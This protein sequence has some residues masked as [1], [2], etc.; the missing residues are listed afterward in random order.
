MSPS[1]FPANSPVLS[2]QQ[3]QQQQQRR[4]GTPSYPANA[5]TS[6]A[7]HLSNSPL[8]SNTSASGQTAPP[9]NSSRIPLSRGGLPARNIQDTTATVG[10]PPSPAAAALSSPSSNDLSNYAGDDEGT[11]SA[12]LA[13]DRLSSP[14]S[15]IGLPN[16]RLAHLQ[17][18]ALPPPVAHPADVSS[19]SI[20]TPLAG[21]S[22]LP[23][24]RVT[25]LD[26]R[27]SSLTSSM[28]SG[29]AS[30]SSSSS[31]GAFNG[32]TDGR[33]SGVRRQSSEYLAGSEAESRDVTAR[34]NPRKPG[35][36]AGDTKEGSAHGILSAAQEGSDEVSDGATASPYDGDVEFAA[37]TPISQQVTHLSSAQVVANAASSPPM[38]APATLADKAGGDIQTAKVRDRENPVSDVPCRN[39]LATGKARS[40][41]RSSMELSQE[42]IRAQ[43]TALNS[44]EVAAA[45]IVRSKEGDTSS[46][47]GPNQP[48][49]PSRVVRI[50][51]QASFEDLAGFTA[52]TAQWRVAKLSGGSNSTDALSN[53]VTNTGKPALDAPG[54][55]VHVIVGVT[56]AVSAAQ[57]ATS[58]S[59]ADRAMLARNCRWVDEVVEDVPPLDRVPD[60]DDGSATNQ[61]L[62]EIGADFL[63]Q[64]VPMTNVASQGQNRRT[65]RLPDPSSMPA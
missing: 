27:S 11:I 9:S 48:R 13:G 20:P 37:R 52:S 33:V 25:P 58:L 19:S 6:A 49:D 17:L 43:I 44:S 10:Q 59:P 64:F 41:S 61:L 12:D 38:P 8:G 22:P 30:S 36:E 28:T 15:T 1:A 50:Y 16:R 32:Y 26:A 24:P 7:A 4:T 31:V 55:G 47:S 65:L 2:H 56:R 39:Y 14:T 18:E 34:I 53:S 45:A 21:I 63:A 46:R 35:L 62:Q 51:V 29:S 3:Q 5:S 60:D 23:T 40:S 54:T 57:S 42:D